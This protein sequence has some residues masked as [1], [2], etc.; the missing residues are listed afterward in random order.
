MRILQLGKWNGKYFFHLAK[1]FNHYRCSSFHMICSTVFLP[2]HRVL[3]VQNFY[4]CFLAVP[5]QIGQNCFT[6]VRASKNKFLY[7]SLS[8]GWDIVIQS[9]S[10][11]NYLGL[12]VLPPAQGSLIPHLQHSP[13]AHAILLVPSSFEATSVILSFSVFYHSLPLSAL[14][15][16]VHGENCG[17][18]MRMC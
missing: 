13:Q 12:I 6:A 9:W 11:C 16:T 18:N 8:F 7:L 4:S 17:W 14:F 2:N 3:F 10:G 15:F 1:Q 5:E